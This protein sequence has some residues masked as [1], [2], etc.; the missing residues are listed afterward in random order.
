MRPRQGIRDLDSVLGLPSVSSE[1]GKVI[2]SP[3]K[4]EYMTLKVPFT[5]NSSRGLSYSE[6]TIPQLISS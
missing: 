6:E 2:T 3:R 1:T 4:A 5:S